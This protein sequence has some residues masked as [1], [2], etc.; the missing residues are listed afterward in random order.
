[1][2]A[3]KHR[4]DRKRQRG[5]Q[6]GADQRREQRNEHDLRTIDG[7]DVAAG[8]AQRLHGGDRAALA[9]EVARDRIRDA[10]PADQQCRER[11]QR[12]E[13]AEPLD[14]AFELRR[15]LVARARF[16][17]GV[18]K[19]RFGLLLDRG[20]GAVAC[21]GCGE[22]DPVLPAHQTAGLQ[23]GAGAQSGVAYQ[24]PRPETDPAGEPVR[25][26][27]DRRAQFD[28][29]VADGDAVAGL[30]IE[31]RQQG[32][33][34]CAAEGVALLRQQSRHRQQRIGR[35]RA[36][37]RIGAVHGLDLDK[38]GAPVGGARHRRHGGDGG[39]R[40][41]RAEKGAFAFGRFA[42]DQRESDV[43]AKDQA[44]GAGKSFGQAVRHRADACDRQHAKRNAG[45][46]NAE[47]AQS[48]AQFAKGETQRHRETGFCMCR[49]R[50]RASGMK[51]ASTKWVGA[52]AINGN[53]ANCPASQTQAG[54]KVCAAWSL[55]PQT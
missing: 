20:D 49:L 32:G 22:P 13:L 23:Q 37:Q 11:D 25:L 33:I 6:R 15:R 50:H 17:A 28:D 52:Q 4:R 18:G 27:F 38:G 19:F 14:V 53:P 7:E 51:R 5:A 16:P 55:M 54:T 26:R 43:A 34:G 1:M 48:A 8:R 42:L 2:M 41:L 21:V 10:D 39:E 12:Q 44:A 24:K 40:A 47:A 36:Q 35:D 3:R 9:R 29:G 46:K 30:E 45:D 31:P